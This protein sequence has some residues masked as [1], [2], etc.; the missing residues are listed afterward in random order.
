MDIAFTQK[1][2]N[3][4]KYGNAVL[5]PKKNEKKGLGVYFKYPSIIYRVTS[6]RKLFSNYAPLM[7]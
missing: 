1:V 7:I 5:V 6:L 3:I 2:K 4:I